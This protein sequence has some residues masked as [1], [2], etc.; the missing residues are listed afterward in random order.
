MP[1]CSQTLDSAV[2]TDSA[3]SYSCSYILVNTECSHLGYFSAISDMQN[4]DHVL[5][6]NELKVAFCL[7]SVVVGHGFNDIKH[8]LHILRGKQF[9]N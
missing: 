1:G 6:R 8:G 7:S 4:G 2:S 5:L 9:R 3:G